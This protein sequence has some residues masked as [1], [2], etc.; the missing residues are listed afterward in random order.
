MRTKARFSGLKLSQADRARLKKMLGGRSKMSV[1]T[2]RRIRTLM[3]LD[4][5]SS[6]TEAA[7]AVGAYRRET[8]RIGKRYLAGGLDH[9]L[10]DDARPKPSPL[11]DSTQNAAVVAMVCGP[12]PDGFARWS[13]RLVAIEAVKRGVT[14][15]LGRETARVVLAD[16]G[17]KPWRKKNVVRSR[18][19]NRV[20]RADG[21][22]TQ[23]LR[24]SP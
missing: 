22:R 20:H 16:H 7:K 19:H 9:A 14:P 15:R 24:S 13:V 18:N 10:S 21:G 2:W 23:A 4:E 17:L 5:G 6:I 8:G 12:P 1:R 3:L 11:L